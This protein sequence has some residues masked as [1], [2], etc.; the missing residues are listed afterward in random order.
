MVWIALLVAPACA[1]R[2][3]RVAA[4]IPPEIGWVALLFL[5]AE[6]GL[7]A[8]TGVMRRTEGEVVDHLHQ[9]TPE[10]AAR[11]VL[12]GLREDALRP[13]LNLPEQ[14]GLLL[15]APLGLAGP[16][17]A[18]LPIAWAAG[19]PAL[20]DPAWLSPEP[21]PEV[22]ARWLPPCPRLLSDQPDPLVRFGTNTG[23]YCPASATQ[24]GCRLNADLRG[25]LSRPP[26]ELRLDGR[27]A[28]DPEGLG[29]DCKTVAPRAGARLSFRCTSGSEDQ[30]DLYVPPMPEPFLVD[31][32]SLVMVS[33]PAQRLAPLTRPLSGHLRSVIIA[34]SCPGEPV[35]V[36]RQANPLDHC[37]PAGG[38]LIFVDPRDLSVTA[39]VALQVP[40]LNHLAPDPGGAGFFGVSGRPI[41]VTHFDC[42][43][44]PDATHRPGVALADGLE[45]RAITMATRAANRD[46]TDL[47]VG[48]RREV[49]ADPGWFWSFDTVARR[50]SDPVPV[51]RG[52]EIVSIASLGPDSLVLG[53]RALG[54]DTGVRLH[55]TEYAGPAPRWV[56]LAYGATITEKT[57]HFLATHLGYAIV[58]SASGNPRGI[59]ALRTAQ[60]T[61][62]GPTYLDDSADWMLYG[63]TSTGI[64]WPGS[65]YLLL[66]TTA[67]GFPGEGDPLPRTIAGLFDPRDQHF[68]P[69][70]AELGYGPVS[71][72]AIDRSGAVWMTLTWT[73]ELLRI[74]ARPIP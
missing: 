60:L 34:Q 68:L 56:Q 58:G 74:R 9:L 36:L 64:P 25:C 23:L 42:R 21:T 43:G 62:S 61:A 45:V 6:G 24:V 47:I 50:F 26:P 17:E 40:C 16:T 14:E 8:S 66:P 38:S 28:L 49:E 59:P 51:E 4:E 54:D 53:V 73:G 71:G 29:P 32:T 41:T 57:P 37:G 15:D 72:A 55:F 63:S 19:G 3:I 52:G 70:R 48:T 7:V 12:L 1:P 5:E 67:D 39:T 33:D 18:L 13:F 30:A 46:L 35:I 65:P 44:R 22:T 2:G 27:G 31:R 20:D 69:G 11:M 10:G